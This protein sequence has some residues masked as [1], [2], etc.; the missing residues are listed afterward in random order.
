MN[1][2]A[3]SSL[4]LAAVVTGV[5]TFVLVQSY[6]GLLP[7]V[8]WTAVSGLL[9]AV[10]N[11]VLALRVRRAVSDGGIGFDRSQMHPVTVSRYLALGQATAA[12][13]ALLTGFGAG[14][15]A[16]FGLNA[17][18]LASAREELP[19]AIAVLVG[20]VAAVAAGIFLE[21]SCEHSSGD[22]AGA[23]GASAT[24]AG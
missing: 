11:L 10:V 19:A 21:R 16:Y 17:E 20:G 12:L 14:L 6:F 24:Q 7:P 3:I 9:V 15:S 2:I 22:D 13:G 4:T 23:D 8:G 18:V 5:A 1:R